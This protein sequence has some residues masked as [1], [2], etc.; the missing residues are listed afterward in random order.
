MRYQNLMISLL[1]LMPVTSFAKDAVPEWAKG[2][3]WYMILPER[4]RNINPTNDPIAKRVVGN[5]N[6]DWQVHP[7]AADWYKRQVWEENRSEPFSELL[8]QRR[9]GGDLV[10][11]FEKL[12]YLKDLGV[13][14][15]YLTPIFESPSIEK[16]GASTF[17]H[18]DNNFGLSREE[19]WSAIETEKDNPEEWTLTS[20][21]ELFSDLLRQA[22]E[23]DMRVVIEAVFSYC[24]RDFWAFKD[25]EKNQQQSKYKDWFE[26]LSWDNPVTPDTVEFSY[27]CWQDNKKFPLFRKDAHGFLTKAVKDYIFNSTRRWMDIDGDGITVDGI[28]GWSIQQVE[29]LS[30]PFWREWN[31][32]VRSLN[33]KAITIS[34]FAGTSSEVIDRYDFNLVKDNPL[35]QLMMDFFVTRRGQEPLSE[36]VRKLNNLKEKNSNDIYVAA[37]SQLDNLTT[38]RIA[39][40]IANSR[41]H[42]GDGVNGHSLTPFKPDSTDRKIQRLLTVFQ[43]TYPGSPM[44]TYGDESGM[45]GG[46]Y[47]DNIKPML[48]KEFVYE[49][50]SY[51]TVRPGVTRL[52]ENRFDLRMF[53][54]YRKLNQLR[55]KNAALRVGGCDEEIVDDEKKVFAYVRREKSN[56]VW[57]FMNFSNEPQFIKVTPGWKKNLKVIDPF[58][59]KK[60]RLDKFDIKFTL[61]PLSSRVL[62]KKK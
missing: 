13:D 51:A 20:G 28:D 50:E 43:L 27:K 57:V 45:W 18:V 46:R 2:A 53:N 48:W 55:L 49:R 58:Q 31:E 24:G 11:V 40:V 39:T 14:A 6:N 29:D 19:D 56:E 15:I 41:E 10:G 47:P 54:T 60:F 3:V 21:D 34:D 7:W 59:L 61:K 12:L 5:S 33:S 26:V 16:Y 35:S 1:L 17:H 42:P 9:Y 38:P 62:V 30:E 32:L 25:L 23:A 36:F 8:A 4:F 37:I 52:S 44:I 22:H